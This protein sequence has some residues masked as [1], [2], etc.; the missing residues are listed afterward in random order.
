MSDEPGA[1]PVAA[2][3]HTEAD[4]D[5]LSWHDCHVH[6]VSLVTGDP[7]HGDWVNNLVLDIDYLTQWS[8]A[9]DGSA[10]FHVAPASLTFHGVTDLRIQIDWSGD[11]HQ[12]APHPAAIDQIERELVVDQRVCLD[13][14]YYAWNVR[15]NWPDGGVIQ[16]G[17]VGFTQRLRA[18]PVETESQH[19]STAQRRAREG[20]EAVD[21]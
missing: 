19:L 12:V 7:A 2:A 6:G 1:P 13:R 9:A 15:F 18:E 10:R 5:Q 16:F 3:T 20:L 17:A 21:G 8:C 14:P 4:F 11:R